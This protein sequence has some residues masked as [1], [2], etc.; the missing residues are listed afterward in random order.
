ME[1]E[2][3]GSSDRNDDEDNS[4]VNFYYCSYSSSLMKMI[5]L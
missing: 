2:S 4:E 1:E 3:E 5:K